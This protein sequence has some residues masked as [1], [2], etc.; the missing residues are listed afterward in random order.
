VS[1]QDDV[2]D[3]YY[4]FGKPDPLECVSMIAHVAQLTL[5]HELDQAM[6]MVT[7]NAAKAARISDYGIAPGNRADLVVVGAPSVHEAIR[8]QPPRRHVLKGGREVARSV[9]TQELVTS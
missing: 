8:L 4:P 3:P 1:S 7:E 6:S 5:P 9:L 2:N